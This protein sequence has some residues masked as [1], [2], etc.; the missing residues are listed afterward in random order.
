MAGVGVELGDAEVKKLI[1]SVDADK[2]GTV[3]V[4]PC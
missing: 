4:V 3:R 2:S 1:A